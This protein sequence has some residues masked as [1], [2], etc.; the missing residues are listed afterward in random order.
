MSD[1]II[2]LEDSTKL[3]EVVIRKKVRKGF[4]R[5]KT[6]ENRQLLIKIPKNIGEKLNWKKGDQLLLTV[7]NEAGQTFLQ[8]RRK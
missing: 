5:T 1:S 3:Q 8:I 4:L 6:Y 7:I 2:E